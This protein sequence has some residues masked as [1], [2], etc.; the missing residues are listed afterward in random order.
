M[1]VL[2]D[3]RANRQDVAADLFGCTTRGLD[4]DARELLAALGLDDRALDLAIANSAGVNA[5]SGHNGFD[6]DTGGDQRASVLDGLRLFG[7]DDSAL[8]RLDAMGAGETC[9]AAAHEDARKIVVREDPVDFHATGSNHDCLRM[10][11][12]DVVF[13]QSEDHWALVDADC[14]GATRDLN[15]RIAGSRRCEAIDCLFGR[16]G[17]NAGTRC[18]LL[19]D[20]HHALATL[21]CRNGCGEASNAS[22][23]H[24]H[25]GVTIDAIDV[26]GRIRL[27]GEAKTGDAADDALCEGPGE[28]RLCHRLVVETDGHQRMHLVDHVECVAVD[29][30]PRVL[31]RD[32]LTI[33]GCT[34]A[35]TDVDFAVDGDEAVRAVTR[36]AV[37][38]TRTVILE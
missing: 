9:C 3:L 8:A 15:A 14:S 34:L 26:D 30:R 31:A 37:K 21:S 24:E 18:P 25:V 10:D 11:V 5:R 33:L 19:V 22:T 29:R 1:H 16:A 7:P 6:D 13:G 28:L 12:C 20:D 32:D 17:G 35:G 27:V 4:D 2:L 23:N 38:P 36:E